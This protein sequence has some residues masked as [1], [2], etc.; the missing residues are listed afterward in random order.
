M[1]DVVL[2]N[3][4]GSPVTYAGVTAVQLKT[5][6]GGMQLYSEGSSTDG[7]SGGSLYRNNAIEIW[8]KC[9]VV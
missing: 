8:Y 7:G 4:S 6:D 5:P 9:K 1:A 2:K 3:K